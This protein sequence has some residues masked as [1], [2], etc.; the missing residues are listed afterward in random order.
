M[1]FLVFTDMHYSDIPQ[2]GERNRPESL[3]KVKR[4]ISEHSH[5]CD[6][7]INLGDTADEAPGG[8]S[9]VDLWK[10]TY[11]EMN[12]SGKKCYSLI[13]NHDTSTDKNTWVKVMGM[14]ARYYSFLCDGFKV[15]CLD[16]NNNDEKTAFP[17]KEILWSEVY[18]D[19][20]QF[21]W[22]KKEIEEAECEI[23]IFSHELL[24][25][26]TED[27]DDDHVLRNREKVIDL[28][29]KS[30]K[31]RAFFAG[32]YHWGDYVKHG[33]VDYITFR[34]IC[35]ENN[36]SHAVVTVDKDKITVE[37]FEGQASFIT[38]K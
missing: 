2:E 29:E 15:I 38:E 28:I 13:G 10:K 32:H 23:L 25:L 3:N 9:Q 31:V 6:F 24:I 35:L 14:S 5:D 37:G 8:I 7:I 18:I 22:L 33:K 27:N 19:D 11:E 26:K 21:D 1:K 17:K 36:A 34:S 16:P 30:G 12:E 20:E 4:I